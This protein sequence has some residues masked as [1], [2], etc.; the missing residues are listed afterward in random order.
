[1]PAV[2]LITFIRDNDTV[3]GSVPLTPARQ[4]N[5]DSP[6][7][8]HGLPSAAAF[9]SNLKT[10]CLYVC[11]LFIEHVICILLHVRNPEIHVSRC[12]DDVSSQ[13][14]QLVALKPGDAVAIVGGGSIG[15][16]AAAE[17]IRAG[18]IPTVY[19]RESKIGGVWA[20]HAYN[21][22]YTNSS[23]RLM[24][25]SDYPFPSGRAAASGAL[26]PSAREIR[27]YVEA[28]AAAHGVMERIQFMTEVVGVDLIIENKRELWDVSF[29]TKSDKAHIHIQR[30]CAVLVCSGQFHNP[31]MPNWPGRETYRGH[32]LHS[33][34]YREPSALKGRRVLIVG[35]GN[36][37]LDIALELNR[38][39]AIVQVAAR[40]GTV[41]I[42]V[43]SSSGTPMDGVLCNRFFQ[44][45]LPSFAR[46][47]YF[48]YLVRSLN[49][50]FHAAGMPKVPEGL[51][52][53][54]VRFSNVK[55]HIE[56]I[57]VLKSGEIKFRPG[58]SELTES[59]VKFSDGTSAAFDTIICCTGY[60]L[61]FA[62]DPKLIE[63]VT[64][65]Y[66]V[67]DSSIE[68][69]TL[70]KR[71]LHPEHPSLGFLG[72]VTCFG[73]EA[74]V[75]ELQSRWAVSILCARARVGLPSQRLLQKERDLQLADLKRRRPLF[76]RYV[77]YI[78]YCD[79]LAYD[80]GC[81]PPSLSSL[82]LQDPQLAYALWM[83]PHVM[84]AYR[85]RGPD[86]WDDARN[87]IVHPKL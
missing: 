13:M 87:F 6:A 26:F 28:N 21:S 22:L 86:S 36:S 2:T 77:N 55:E 66:S 64:T 54:Q 56:W 32:L 62:V 9:R 18:L 53:Q 50:A 48:G 10:F 59:D 73:N 75:G 41:A 5:R 38:A 43:A 31:K 17:C 76:P 15:I 78:K 80:I 82:W 37:A 23:A 25:L 68:A 72:F 51:S 60:K 14:D 47:L 58:V 52:P 49:S 11:L 34:D 40:T 29:C 65:N 69:M 16:S 79:E 19:E 81:A 46:H 4:A 61:A 33:R 12:N 74:A 63:P 85:L 30:F 39:G 35:V 45:T 57:R 8:A 7:C 1:M 24:N 27:E 44:Q 84:A 83:K 71:I 20:S 42:P 3:K 70:F 67:G